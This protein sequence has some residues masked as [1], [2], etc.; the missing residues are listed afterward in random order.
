MGRKLV[1]C[2]VFFVLELS[3]RKIFFTP[4]GGQTRK[5]LAL[6]RESILR[7]FHASPS[8]NSKRS[9]NSCTDVLD[10]HLVADL[11]AKLLCLTSQLFGPVMHIGLVH[12]LHC[13]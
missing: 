6:Y 3:T 13:L 10:S 12:S 8:I 1:R 4:I 7:I 5:I 2:T 11:G 9:D